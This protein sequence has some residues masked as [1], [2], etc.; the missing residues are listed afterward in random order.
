MIVYS[1][2]Y[3]TEYYPSAPVVE[4]AVRHVQRANP[5]ILITA[6]V[7]SGAD[8]SMI[9]INVLRAVGAKRLGK[10]RVRGISGLA[11]SAEI[12]LATIRIGPH[13]IRAMQVIAVKTNKEAIIGRDVLNDLVVTLNGLAG[14]IEVEA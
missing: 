2:E 3:S 4:V 11:Y 1:H 12:Y 5:E 10:R 7:D 8:A 9:P 14:V 6:L 13:L